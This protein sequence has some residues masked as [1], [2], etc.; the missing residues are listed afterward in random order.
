MAL[1]TF[2]RS[3]DSI[4]DFTA[5]QSDACA[6]SHKP[7]FERPF[8]DRTSKQGVLGT[9]GP[10]R[11]RSVDEMT[12][13][14]S[15]RKLE[16]D[17]RMSWDGAS[18][19]QYDNRALQQPVQVPPFRPR[20][21]PNS[22]DASRNEDAIVLRP[23][24]EILPREIARRRIKNGIGVAAEVVQMPPCERIHVRFC[25][26]AHLFV[27]TQGVRVAGETSVDGRP[28]STLR[29]LRRKLTFVPAGC[30][31]HERHQLSGA[32]R[33]TF[34][35]FDPE[36]A[37]YDLKAEPSSSLATPRLHFED[38]A[39]WETALKLTRLIKDPDGNSAACLEALG[40]ILLHE[41]VQRP[42][43]AS[44]IRFPARGGLAGWQ[45][46]LLT[47]YIEENLARQI[48]LADLAGLVRLHPYHLCRVFK[49]SFGVPPHRYHN[50][51]RIER[52]KS[53][54]AS[55][56]YSITEIG[57]T[58][59][60]SETSAFSTAFHKATGAAPTTYRGGLL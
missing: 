5:S 44:P 35:Y 33:A 21:Q 36:N 59:G 18:V 6:H 25:A 54:L 38:A 40:V 3:F 56:D 32:F 13:T 20:F 12:V 16:A 11:R 49:Q 30:A 7:G 58:V 17:G 52:A 42:L 57:L 23:T 53:L 2:Q 45:Q 46:R 15:L 9:V 31:Y 41:L 39:L 14:P 8:D 47:E 26:R 24:V 37:S 4:P 55:G 48:S 60:F 28:P 1:T 19:A 50:S 29:D 10:G 27:A 34:A 51:R 22:T 43:R